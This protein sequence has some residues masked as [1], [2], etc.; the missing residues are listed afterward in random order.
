VSTVPDLKEPVVASAIPPP[1]RVSAARTAAMVA[2]F[3][4]RE[5]RCRPIMISDTPLNTGSAQLNVR[6][7][8]IPFG[9]EIGG[10]LTFVIDRICQEIGS[11]RQTLAGSAACPSSGRCN[12]RARPPC[13]DALEDRSPR[14][15]RV[16]NP[17]HSPAQQGA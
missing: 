16:W 11:S 3:R 15:N 7:Q 14:P 8:R 9:P 12:R 2:T 6:A 13:P 4:F 1:P 5:P 17:D 10:R